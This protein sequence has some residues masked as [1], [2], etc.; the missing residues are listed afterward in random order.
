MLLGMDYRSWA[1]ALTVAMALFAPA[2]WADSAMDR[3]AEAYDRAVE[4]QERGELERAAREFARADELVPSDVALEAAL[5]AALR[6]GDARLAMELADRAGRTSEARVTALA[7]DARRTMGPRVGRLRVACPLPC[8]VSIDGEAASPSGTV[9]LLPGEHRVELSRGG[10]EAEIRVVQIE[11]GAQ[12]DVA[13]TPSAEPTSEPASRV[14]PQPETPRELPGGAE[15]SARGISPWWLAG[16]AGVAAALGVGAGLAWAD[17]QGRH[18]EFIAQGCVQ[19]GSP[20]C[21]GIAE[22]GSAALT[23]TNVLLGA[24][25]VAVVAT[26]VVAVVFVDWKPRRSPSGGLAGPVFTF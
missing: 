25:A 9:W 8:E 11:G 7:S 4:A 20:S 24:T 12:V 16:G 2:A 6:A 10:G 26:A 5:A 15:A 13:P 3:A 21:S 23:R 17:A 14:E 1:V 19:V 22:D 18:D